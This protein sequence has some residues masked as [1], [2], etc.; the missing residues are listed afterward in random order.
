MRNVIKDIFAFWCPPSR[1][2]P[3]AVLFKKFQ[4]ILERNNRILEL[5][6]DMGDKLGGEYV[7]DRHFIE[8]ATE[9]LGDH[10]FKLISDLS[11]L[12]QRKNVELFTAFERIQHLLWQE[13]AGR[14]PV[15]GSSYVLNLE[16]LGCDLTEQ[17]GAKMGHIGDLRN[18]LG[19]ATPDGFVITTRAFFDFMNQNDL[20]TR[21][22]DGIGAWDGH[23][24]KALT[25]LAEDMRRRILNAPLPRGL[26]RQVSAEAARLIGARTGFDALLA[27]RSSAWH[28][29]GESS[30]A[31]QYSSVLDVSADRIMDAYREVLASAYAATAWRYRI[32]RGYR[33]HEVGMAVG[34]QFMIR[35][36]VSGVLHTYAPH[37]AEGIMAANAV[38][39]QCASVVDGSATTQTVI[40]ERTEPYRLRTV[41]S[42]VGRVVLGAGG[43]SSHVQ[44]MIETG[45]AP[46][47]TEQQ[48]RELAAAAMCIE[49]YYKRPQDIE[50]TFDDQGV[51]H[52]L[53]TRPLRFWAAPEDAEPR[54][55]AAT[56]DAEV[57]F[58]GKGLVAQR[59]VAVGRV[60][61]VRTDG[62]LENFPIGGILVAQHTSPRYSR[63][64]R[65]ARGIIT[66]VG[67][68]MGH[69]ATIAREFRVPALVNAGVATT[70]LREGE[71]ITLDTTQNVV[72]RGRISALDR[73]EL[74]EADVF[75]DSYEYR[76]LRRLLKHI[77]PLNL[78]DPHGENFL[79]SSCR[80]YHDITRFIHESAVNE[81]ISLSERQGVSCT[82]SPRRL[83]TVIPLG[84]VLVDAGGGIAC[85][86]DGKVFLPE[87]IVSLPMREFLIGIDSCGT[88]CTEPVSVDL[89]SFMSSLTRTFS[90]PQAA[91]RNLAVVLRNYMNVH[92]RL[93]YH[94]NI[95]DAYLGDAINDNYIYFRFMGGVTDFIRRSRRAKFVADVLERFDFRV[96]IHGD[97]VVGRVKKLDR[98]RMSMRLR[99]LGGLV[100]YARQLDARM[101]SEQD[102]SRHV[103]IFIDAM[104]DVIK[105]EHDE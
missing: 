84:L 4:S 43:G 51:L 26:A 10:V 14:S 24:E 65:K 63:V 82:S 102:V 62:D 98:A 66:D 6:A 92:M 18:R 74:T 87:Q 9:Q 54:V 89:G 8:Q 50:W 86:D 48:G 55:D 57:I 95:I 39:G 20:L 99:M 71:E 53:Q 29:D 52:I 19:L 59:G 7:F 42:A 16:S 3:F 44:T 77:A 15:T 38:R 21:A 30:F 97:L 34:C 35:G 28:E 2:L 61:V 67:S 69:M 73:F 83:Q 5:M 91:G 72:Y 58:S 64:M 1:Q 101:H 100:G 36:A 11:M 27:V 94:F 75:E 78:V 76:L 85:H 60:R 96:E 37:V 33:E 93:G 13:L 45:E 88:W 31:G 105:G 12:A 80:T 81:L 17:T 56:R 32:L 79:P 41:D 104:D 49:R 103:R 90:N 40:M 46:L 23:D 68:P 47:L 22:V 25:D 70:L